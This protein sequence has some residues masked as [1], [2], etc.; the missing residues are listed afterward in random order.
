M[1]HSCRRFLLSVLLIELLHFSAIAYSIKPS[2]LLLS[3]QNPE[4]EDGD[5]LVLNCTILPDYGGSY[6]NRHLY[7]RFGNVNYTNVT[8][9]G[10]TT[11]LLRL[12][13]HVMQEGVAGGH[14]RCV[15]PDRPFVWSAIQDVTVVRRPLR[16]NV[17]N[18]LVR[19][20][21]VVNCTWQPSRDYQQEYMHTHV[22][23]N[24]TIEWRMTNDT[25]DSFQMAVCK[26]K[27]ASSCAWNISPQIIDQFVKSDGC[28][29]RVTAQLSL[30]HLQF[31]EQ[32]AQFCFSPVRNLILDKP[33]NVMSVGDSSRQIVLHWQAPLLNVTNVP[34]LVYAVT[35]TAQWS[36]APVIN[37]SVSNHSFSFASI[38][39]TRYVIAVRVKT[40]ES[41][42]W[43]EAD[44]H[45][46]TTA[47]AVPRMSPSTSTNA[48]RVRHMGR[49]T[50]TVMIYWQTLAPQDY[51]GRWLRYVLLTRVPPSP[52]W[53]ELSIVMSADRP[54]DEV[55][56]DSGSDVELTVIARNEVGD[57]RPGTVI[58]LPAVRSPG[59][60]T[61]SFVE[62]AVELI[63]SSAVAWSWKLASADT[64]LTLF[65]C[66][67][68]IAD[69]AHCVGNIHWLDV[70]AS[71]AQYDLSV[72][73]AST[74]RYSYGA[75]V[76]V[77]NHLTG[78]GGG[79]EWVTC[80]YNAT[81]L[82]KPVHDVQALVPSFGETVQLLVTWVLPRCDIQLS[83]VRTLL[84]FYCRQ[85]ANECVGEPNSVSLPGYLTAFNLTGLEHGAEYRLWMYS[86]TQSGRSPT[87]SNVVVVVTSS[88]VFTP[89]V[90]A[91]ICAGAV[92]VLVL[93]V[94]VI[95]R[96]SKYC[97]R[98]RAKFFP[99][100]K[101]T[102]PP[103]TAPSNPY[104]DT[105]PPIIEYSRISYN[106][107]GSRLSSSSHDSG[108][109]GVAGGSPLLTPRSCSESA[110]AV[111]L[112]SA[113]QHQNI[114]PAAHV[115]PA[116]MMYVNDGNA[117]P[118]HLSN[119]SRHQPGP[120]EF[121]PLQPL[122]SR[123][124]P[125]MVASQFLSSVGDGTDAAGDIHTSGNRL[126]G[127]YHPIV[128]L[129]ESDYISH[130][131]LKI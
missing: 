119:D 60:M 51:H 74:R 40:I 92:L 83:Y 122:V 59:T 93:A 66:R 58:H 44:Y 90:I 28:C 124:S 27:V 104:T 91:G 64:R 22:S 103:N 98:C 21:E 82:A 43:S 7:F 95:W 6:T 11:A 49:Y 76:K 77:E 15:L 118:R 46:F 41:N 67:S 57:T 128:L 29:V 53:R 19:S 113:E 87:H 129:P 36:D 115:Q 61:G 111:P 33:R 56:V 20:W 96:L 120:V 69:V 2:E 35:V 47:S 78:A 38:P 24:Q 125:D 8:L 13:W 16:P 14:V 117:L 105:S 99:Q 18:C 68:Q 101:I 114:S 123:P 112:M 31:D 37:M 73:A 108:Q 25:E 94:I 79:I 26:E 52:D 71:L 32:S 1:S 102:V 72:G 12:Q 48:Y 65:W 54:C 107:Q 9:V 5:W 10:S 106:R 30:H 130:E 23:L 89:A 86:Q 126:N 75:A 97:R 81:G 109:F 131:Q 88:S 63:N 70:S 45:S 80:L 84:L 39:H 3:P 17:T 121:I 62:L 50:K 55:V 110:A 127:G 85:A 4:V 42:F 100:M 116:P 34:D